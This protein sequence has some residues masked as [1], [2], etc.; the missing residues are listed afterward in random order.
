[1]RLQKMKKTKWLILILAVL[2]MLGGCAKTPETG[3]GEPSATAA[4]TPTPT[5]ETT[6]NPVSG[7]GK[8]LSYYVSLKPEII[9]PFTLDDWTFCGLTYQMTKEEAVGTLG[10]PNS[11]EMIEWAADGSLYEYQY[12]DFGWVAYQEGLLELAGITE[13]GYTGP[14][15]VAVGDSLEDVLKKFCTTV[16][17]SDEDTIIFYRENSGRDNEA[18]L[19]PCGVLSIYDNKFLSYT[20]SDVA[21]YDGQDITDLESYIP[22]MTDYSFYMYFDENDILT[23]YYLTYGAAAE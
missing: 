12:Y 14:R 3:G 7:T 13:P 4:V 15:G 22:Y 5:P 11:S 10:E 19:P 8:P 17:K 21:E 23:A 9:E 1:M 16:E 6:V 18:A 20:W 2:L